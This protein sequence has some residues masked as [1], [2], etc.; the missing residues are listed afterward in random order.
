MSRAAQRP[1]VPQYS[2][3]LLETSEAPPQTRGHSSA[4]RIAMTAPTTSNEGAPRHGSLGRLFLI[5]FVILFF[6]LACI[7]WFGSTVIFL[8]FFTNI[9][10]LACFLGH[11]GRLP[12]GVAAGVTGRRSVA[13][14]AAASRSLLAY[15]VLWALRHVRQRDR[16][17]SAGRSRRSRSTSAPSIARATSARFVV[18]IEV[19]A[20]DF[21][22]LIALM[23]VGARAGD[24]PG[25]QR[26]ARPRRRL[27]D[28]HRSAAWPGSRRSRWRRISDDAAAGL[29]RPSAVGSGCYF[30]RTR[31]RGSRSGRRAGS[32]SADRWSAS[33]E[34]RTQ[35]ITWS[36]YYKIRYHPPHRHHRH[37]QHR[38]PADGADRRD[39]AR[40]TCCRT[41]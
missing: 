30:L 5:S 2:S 18:P 26:D 3:C 9:V 27:H 41:C 14:A 25:V 40:R 36:P 34:R 29:V 12:G 23:F 39:A 10:L 16:S 15:G 33:L 35:P 13:P 31:Q 28:E 20:G 19:L 6:E 1:R 7:R 17:T 21:F 37:Q 32:L 38:P 4:S 24:G 8:T 11:V 22:V